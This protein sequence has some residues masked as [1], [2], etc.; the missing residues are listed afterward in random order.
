[1]PLYYERIIDGRQ[2]R[3]YYKP[4]NTCSVFILKYLSDEDFLKIIKDNRKEYLMQY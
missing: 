2:Y 3:I 4:N 1:M